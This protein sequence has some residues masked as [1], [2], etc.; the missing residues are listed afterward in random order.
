MPGPASGDQRA[1]GHPPGPHRDTPGADV[2]QRGKRPR[3]PTRS[4]HPAVAVSIRYVT[5]P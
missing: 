4:D 1:T 2:P 3:C 5:V